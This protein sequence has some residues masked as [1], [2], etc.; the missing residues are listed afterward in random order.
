MYSLRGSEQAGGVFALLLEFGGGQKGKEI[1]LLPQTSLKGP[2]GQIP[3]W[4]HGL[5]WL[6]LCVCVCVCVSV[7]VVWCTTMAVHAYVFCRRPSKRS[8]PWAHLFPGD[9]T[10]PYTVQYAIPEVSVLSSTK[11]THIVMEVSLWI[12]A[13]V[14]IWGECFFFTSPILLFSYWK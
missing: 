2:L 5:W 8:V 14:K 9:S 4:W 6:K 13:L 12:D 11:F 10:I 7:V 1:Y 3:T